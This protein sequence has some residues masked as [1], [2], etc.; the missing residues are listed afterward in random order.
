[1][2]EPHVQGHQYSRREATAAN[3]R[4]WDCVYRHCASEPALQAAVTKSQV[5]DCSSE[6]HIQGGSCK[7]AITNLQV[8]GCSFL[9][10]GTMRY[11]QEATRIQVQGS[12]HT[13]TVAVC[14]QEVARRKV[15]SYDAP[16]VRVQ[17][18][19]WLQ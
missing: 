19:Q 7:A 12:K 5:Q 13:V 10:T 11:T 6:V 4:V 2:D 15:R 9:V 3:L 18:P 14:G 8:W 17:S 16:L 1:M